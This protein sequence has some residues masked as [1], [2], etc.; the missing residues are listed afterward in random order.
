MIKLTSFLPVR[1]ML[2]VCLAA[3]GKII[4][5]TPSAKLSSPKD[6][7]VEVKPVEYVNVGYSS[8][9]RANL[10]GAVSVVDEGSIKELTGVSINALLQGQAAGV[11][12]V[13]TS[14]AP[15]S[16][17]I[18][19]IR[20]INTINGGTAPLY[21][22]DGIPVKTSRFRSLAHNVDNDPLA[23]I[24]PQDIASISILKDGQ[25]TAMY[26]MRG[27]NGVIII[28]TYGGTSGK[29]YL[30]ISSFV[31]I[32]QAPKELPVLDAD[33]YRAYTLAKERARGF[34]QTQINN[35]IG[36]YLLLSTPP[37]QVERY[38]NNTDWQE[39]AFEKGMYSDFHLNL[40][41]GDAVA[42]YSLNIGYTDIKG[43]VTETDFQRFSTRFNLD[44]KVGKKLSF[45][46][47]LTYTRTDK[48]VNDAGEAFNSNPLVLNT[49][50]S[51]TLTAFQQNTLGENQRDLDSAD[52]AGRNNPYAVIN[53]LSN[54]TNTNRILG[55]ITGQYTFSPS[56]N[57]RVAIAGDYYRMD[58]TRYRPSQGFMTEKEAIR[59]SA[60]A[61][62][63]ELMLLNE[64]TLNYTKA[65][66][67]GKHV[68]DATV[69]S[70]YQNTN[71]DAKTAV[72][73]NAP[74]DLF[75]GITSVG[76][77]GGS[78]PSTDPNIDT[79]MSSSPGWKLMSFFATAQY[80]FK[81]KYILS[82]NFRADGSSRFAANHRWGYFPGAAAAWKISKESF[83][84]NSK[85]ISEL[86]LRAGFGISGNQEVGYYNAFNALISSPYNRFS[87]IRVGI[88]GNP[89]FTWE[90]T[91]QGDI[92]IDAAFFGDRLS[93]SV[94]GYRRRTK[95]L[96]NTIKLPGLSGFDNYAVSE[97]E[98]RNYGVELAIGSKILEG[99]F[100]WQLN[101]NAAYNKNKILSL[102]EKLLPIV[103]Y[104]TYSGF[105]QPG[106]AIG[107]FYGYNAIG[108][109]A[110]TADVTLKN[111]VNNI[112]PF[113][114]GDIIFEDIDENGII[115]ERDQKVI[116]N[117]NP[118]FFGGISNT[119]SYKGF[120]LN[121]FMDFAEG[122][123]VYNAQR[124]LLESM[125]N[126]DNQ[127]AS[128]DHRWYNP[129]DITKLPRALHGDPVGNTR[130]SS[131]WIEDGSY[132]RF[133]AITLG[134]NF[135]LKGSL[136]SVFKTARVLATAQ[137]IY[138]FS[139]NGSRYTGF[140]PEVAN[141][142]NPIMYGVDNGNMPQLRTF[143]LG[144]RLGL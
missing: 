10:A 18:L 87:G 63:Y 75:S 90:S 1:F 14:G 26:G 60:A 47:T 105:Q 42:K 142:S 53:G 111:G 55:R 67:G 62:S 80:T 9:P 88:L 41:G 143:L 36:R 20:G 116:G 6:S 44:Y 120:D 123:E 109:Y 16:G 133:K 92:G 69:G 93:L 17:G 114:G 71:Q 89:D 97:G 110:R 124:A 13:N 144:V 84:Q 128:I 32:T 77:T 51:P 73:I 137:N 40:R 103:S 118:D 37:D 119:F 30:D 61:K 129:G 48:Q 125:S 33:G 122:N 99:K 139:K 49:L 107:A 7:L 138:T 83:L 65:F 98:V 130:F 140:S 46:N 117:P 91:A 25:A 2:I 136:K 76:N 96:Y 64:N 81:E 31:G 121:V 104:E 27:S 29:T 126:Y 21:I 35:G 15:G 45:L 38:N 58:E 94:D 57:L 74:S 134:Y 106:T 79:V 11:K 70:A 85:L 5:Q 4:G 24:N 19:T 132:L 66:K 78:N 135:P 23:D 50:K 108:V 127:S 54:K 131:R 43:V 86:K 113:Q 115:D 34:S 28:N 82:A 112:N 95:H 68:L 39:E 102:P 59:S 56:L 12:V 72:Y 3:S 100:G 101:I 141:I 8:V 22:I 52:Y